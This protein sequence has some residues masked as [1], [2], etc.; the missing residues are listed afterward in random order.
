MKTISYHTEK[1]IRIGI[2]IAVFI[3]AVFATIKVR[4]LQLS[5]TNYT[6]D[7]SSNRIELSVSNFSTMPVVDAKLI[8]EPM[9]TSEALVTTSHTA[10]EHE[11]ALQLKT[12]VNNG[13]YW[14][15]ENAES[16][17]DLALQMTTWLKNGTYYN[18][19]EA[20]EPT[21]TWNENQ[22][23]PANIRSINSNTPEKEVASQMRTWMTKG[24][25][26]SIVNN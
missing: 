10:N 17:V 12:M 18:S 3:M 11:L 24:D 13:E 5:G 1:E 25:Y 23:G 21:A 7:M 8:E 19:E 26:W 14:S 15:D 22:P 20:G 4:E 6:E 9:K 2:M 16:N